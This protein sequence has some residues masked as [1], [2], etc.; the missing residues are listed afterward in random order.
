MT[1]F[2]DYA[3]E[4][5]EEDHRRG[6]QVSAA[7]SAQIDIDVD[8]GHTG[9]ARQELPRVLHSC[10]KEG[11]G[12]CQH[13]DPPSYQARCGHARAHQRAQPVQS[14]LFSSSLQGFSLISVNPGHEHNM[15]TYYAFVPETGRL[16]HFDRDNQRIAELHVREQ[17]GLQ[18]FYTCSQPH[19]RSREMLG[20][21][22]L[23]ILRKEQH[24][25]EHFRSGTRFA[26]L[27]HRA[28]AIYGLSANPPRIPRRV[29]G[30]R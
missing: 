30:S 14:E 8:A 6:D 15:T 2:S 21:E 25:S 20:P 11:V 29:I 27:G 10:G 18:L 22:I 17:K 9:S 13:G 1:G 12:R 24:W 5:N 16:F 4:L 7:S 23:E 28:R 19:Q 3:L 26:S